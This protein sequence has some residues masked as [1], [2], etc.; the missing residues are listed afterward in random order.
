[1]ATGLLGCGAS[2]AHI[3]LFHWGVIRKSFGD[4]FSRGRNS[5]EKDKH[6]QMM[7]MYPEVPQWWFIG[8]LVICCAFGVT[9]SQ[10]NNTGLPIWGFFAA[11][12]LSGFLVF[13]VGFMSATTGF[14]MQT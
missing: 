14:P 5:E 11:I 2:I 7:K 4:I 8:L 10:V 9:L 1:M 6:Y 13:F 12:I 3:L